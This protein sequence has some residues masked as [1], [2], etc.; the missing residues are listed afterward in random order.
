MWVFL[1]LKNV[2]ESIGSVMGQLTYQPYD[3]KLN[4]AIMDFNVNFAQW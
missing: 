4:I 3:T 2:C 1:L